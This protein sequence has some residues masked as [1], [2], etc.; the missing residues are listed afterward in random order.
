MNLKIKYT[1]IEK[2]QHISLIQNNKITNDNKKNFDI[3]LAILRV[4]ISYFVVIAHCYNSSNSSFI[5]KKINSLFKTHVLIFFIMAFYFSYKTIISSNLKKKI[6]RLKRLIIPYILW[7]IILWL[8][9]KLV[10]KNYKR[11]KCITKEDLI[12]QLLYGSR[13]LAVL[14]FQ[15]NLILLTIVFYLINIIFRQ[16]LNFIIII[17]SIGSFIY[18]YNGNNV[19]RFKNEIYDKRYTFG[20]FLEICP[21][22]V[23]GFLF[24]FTQILIYCKLHQF[25]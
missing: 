24:N 19:K 22:A 20:R 13:Y 9:N 15:W 25:R 8:I 18:Q 3:G 17:L 16:H 1:T 23:I 7:P 10:P 2:P 14:W 4:F 21:M 5:F 12:Y 11:A 6:D